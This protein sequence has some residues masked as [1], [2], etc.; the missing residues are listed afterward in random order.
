MNIAQAEDD[1]NIQLP[2]DPFAYIAFWQFL[3]FIILLLLIW[4]NELRDMQA[5]FFTTKP[6]GVNVFRGCI[7]TAGVFFT[8]IVSIGNTYIE[9]K[10]VLRSLNSVC[11]NCH[12]VQIRK[13]VW[14][15]MED[16]VSEQSL[17]TFTH[18]LCPV[19]MAKVMQEIEARP[20]KNAQA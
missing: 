16:Y 2:R 12:R 11:A 13:N 9:E 8:A 20:K 1:D 15:R 4:L 14:S 7:L 18:G 5:F 19:C 10:R 6:E 3:T 17:L